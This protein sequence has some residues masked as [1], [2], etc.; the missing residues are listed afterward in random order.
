MRYIY[1]LILLMLAL[2]PCWARDFPE[3]GVQGDLRPLEYPF[4]KLSGKAIRLAP[5]SRIFDVNNRIIQPNVLP[6]LAAVLYKL[7]N[8][9]DVQNIWILS[10]DEIQYLKK[11]PQ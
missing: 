6:A 11:K 4:V 9:G 5:G 1:T 7:D 3:D 10:A 8:R 2:P